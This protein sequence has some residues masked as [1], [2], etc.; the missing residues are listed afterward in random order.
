VHWPGRRLAHGTVIDISDRKRAEADLKNQAEHD[1]LTGL[2]SRNW[3]FTAL[4]KALC[5]RGRIAPRS[6]ALILVDIDYFKQVN[7]TLGH[8]AGDALLIEIGRRLR[9]KCRADD[10]AARLGGDEFALLI[11]GIRDERAVAS[12]MGDILATMAQ[13]VDIGGRILHVTVSMGA[14]HFPRDGGGAKDLLKNADL[15]LYEAK[16]AGRSCWRFFRPEQ[17][18]LLE[19]HVRMADALRAAI[20]ARTIQIA[21]QPKRRL[22]GAHAG[23]EALARWHDGHRWVPP[24]E[25]IP[26]AEATGLIRPLG[27]Q[28]MDMALARIKSL[29]SK[30]CEPG[31]VAVNVSS[32]DLLDADFVAQVRAGLR[33]YRLAP[34]DL[35]LEVT[36]N[37]LLGRTADQVDSVLQEL[38]ALGVSIALDDFGTGF[39]SLAHISRLSVDRLKID[40]SFVSG[41]GE[42]PRAGL[43]ARTIIALARDLDIESVAEGV[44]TAGQ[45][46]FLAAEGCDAAQG[47]LIARPLL[48][49]AEAAA[50]L[51]QAAVSPLTASAK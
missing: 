37:V 46:A 28:V 45:L 48:S 15:A 29:R 43:I 7:D 30:T 38:R 14:T 4:E 34:A 44:E 32:A 22:N 41:I 42:G 39:A 24:D 17:A 12:R 36:E 20:E 50:Y 6:G 35:E 49:E 18:E 9:T 31:H 5:G 51:M 1:G 27:R 21:L 19:R 8:D 13:P 2:A 26:I 10:I 47:Y 3:F 11:P 23:F 25:F 40:R 33:R 16:R